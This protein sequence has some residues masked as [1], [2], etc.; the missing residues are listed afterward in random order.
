MRVRTAIPVAS[1]LGICCILMAVAL[2][3][4]CAS[5]SNEDT[6]PREEDV[7][8]P[9]SEADPSA[10]VPVEDTPSQEEEVP[11]THTPVDIETLEGFSNIPF[12]PIKVGYNTSNYRR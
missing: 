3:I 9:Y 4:L 1:R 12:E 2:L 11:V 7:T 6:S 8:V 5:G 10:S